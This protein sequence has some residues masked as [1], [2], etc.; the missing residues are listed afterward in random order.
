ME[1]ST[2]LV[3]L[4]EIKVLRVDV[5][6]PQ[7][8]FS[9]IPPGTTAEI[10]FDA[11]PQRSFEARVSMKIPVGNVS[12]RTFPIRMEINNSER[13]I[14]PGMSA[15]VRFMLEQAGQT[16]LLP[17][18][19]IVRKPDG[20]ES[21][22]LIVDD[23][24]MTKARQMSVTTGRAYKDN[25]EVIASELQAGDKAVIRGNEILREDQVVNVVN[26]HEMNL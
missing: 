11:M 23:K 15:R 8:Y 20:S 18:D 19:T 3:E 17:R 21:I 26:E 2:A 25:V 12:T 16:K 10:K 5:P 22:W 7:T 13:L 14:A 1:T 6:V 9:R 4:V 24:G